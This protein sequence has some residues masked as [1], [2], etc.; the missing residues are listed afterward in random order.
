MKRHATSRNTAVPHTS[1]DGQG[2]T[3]DATSESQV[4][5]GDLSTYLDRARVRLGVQKKEIAYWWAC[6]HGYVSR[7]L[8]NLD[9]LPDHRFTELPEALQRATLEEWA[10]DLGV[11]VGRKADLTKA[12]QALARLADEDP[13]R[14][15]LRMAKV[16]LPE[17]PR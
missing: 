12:L 10:L 4:T 15:P 11:T 14:V 8:A 7:V 17:E 2:E 6:D 9:P 1:R 5:R 16:E 13:L 3:R